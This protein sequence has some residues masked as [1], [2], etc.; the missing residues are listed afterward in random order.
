METE[1]SRQRVLELTQK[2]MME[3]KKLSA[4]DA[5]QKAIDKARFE[6]EI[7]EEQPYKNK[8]LVGSSHE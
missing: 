7:E 6:Q 1:V 5:R 2:Y 3:D 4:T 8:G